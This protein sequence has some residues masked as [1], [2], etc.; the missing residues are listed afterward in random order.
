MLSPRYN[1]AGQNF[2]PFRVNHF[3]FDQVPDFS[4]V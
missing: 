1:D 2:I 3:E 4:K